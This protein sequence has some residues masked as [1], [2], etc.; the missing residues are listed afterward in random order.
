MEKDIE[1]FKKI[2]Q[3]LIPI[4]FDY[5]TVKSLST[6]AKLK[7]MKLR[8]ENLSQVSRISGISA[9]D[10]ALLSIYLA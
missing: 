4:D 10:I 8:P 6:E 9:T 1:R 2:E 5:S 7:L 3:K